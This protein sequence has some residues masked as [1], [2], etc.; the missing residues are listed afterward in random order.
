MEERKKEVQRKIKYL[1]QRSSKDKKWADFAKGLQLEMD[2]FGLEAP[3]KI[4]VSR[5]LSISEDKLKR[6]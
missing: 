3:K 6:T 4:E 1:Q 5:G 2:L